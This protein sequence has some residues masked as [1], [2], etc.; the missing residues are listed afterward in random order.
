MTYLRVPE[1]LLDEII[2]N[3]GELKTGPI[4]PMGVYR[5]AL[6]LKEAR[7]EIDRL[8]KKKTSTIQSKAQSRERK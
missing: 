7:E 2:R 3:E 8:K 5:L 1:H 6:D 4:S